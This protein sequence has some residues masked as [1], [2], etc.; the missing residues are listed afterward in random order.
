M[1]AHFPRSRHSL[2]VESS[3]Y[4]FIG[5]AVIIALLAAWL[6]WFMTARVAVYAATGSG[7]LEVERENHPVD[8]PVGGRVIVAPPSMGRLVEAGDV[9]LELDATPE[10]LAQNEALARIQPA[11]S[12]LDSLRD[13]LRAE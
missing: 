4:S 1:S 6:T 8:T 9:L 5:L 12:Q 13:E 2:Q 7:R 10:S 11:V 3:R